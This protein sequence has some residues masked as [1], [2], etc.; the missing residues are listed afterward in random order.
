MLILFYHIQ[1]LNLHVLAVWG[2]AI[3]E[4]RR[5]YWVQCGSGHLGGDVVAL[6]RSRSHCGNCGRLHHQRVNMGY[7]GIATA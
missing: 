6:Y 1:S 7:F 2:V 4:R 5:F 3:Y